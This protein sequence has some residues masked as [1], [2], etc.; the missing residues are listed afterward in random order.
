MG[1]SMGK[2]TAI[3]VA[4]F[5]VGG[6]YADGDGLYLRVRDGG[7][8]KSWIYRYRARGKLHDMGL[9][10]FR[11]ITLAQARRLAYAAR[12][13]RLD[14]ADP[15]AAKRG[16]LAARKVQRAKATGRPPLTE[17]NAQLYRHFNQAAELLYVG[18]S[19]DHW[20]RLSAHSRRTAWFPEVAFITIEHFSTMEEAE[21]AEHLAIIQE[22]PLHNIHGGV[23]ITARRLRA[24][25]ARRE[26]F[27]EPLPPLQRGTL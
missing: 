7:G 22:N 25:M 12:L 19:R 16:E 6:F 3:Q 24:A 10:S 26:K 8:S 14:G 11:D 15:I 18:I 2:L 13:R 1:Q 21:E 5:K 17:S 27:R 4:A 23:R 20:A 9:G